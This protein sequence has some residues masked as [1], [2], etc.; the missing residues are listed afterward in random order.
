[1]TRKAVDLL[2]KDDR[3]IELPR[4]NFP[5]HPARFISDRISAT[6]GHELQLQ[7]R[8]NVR[9]AEA[10]LFGTVYTEHFDSLFVHELIETMMRMGVAMNGE[11]RKENIDCLRASGSTPDAYYNGGVD[12]KKKSFSFIRTSEDVS[13]D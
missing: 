1:M 8:A 4:S 5:E 6:K 11:G 13:D 9:M 2:D 12:S 3:R 10:V 7:T